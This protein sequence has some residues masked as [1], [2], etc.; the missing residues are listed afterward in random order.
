MPI[1]ET[2]ETRDD[3]D[4]QIKEREQELDQM[5]EDMDIAIDDKIVIADEAEELKFTGVREFSDEIKKHIDDAM[6]AADDKFEEMEGELDGKLEE[7]Q[8][9]EKD[10]FDRAKT[11]AH[12]ASEINDASKKLREAIDARTFLDSAR[13]AADEESF[14]FNESE[15]NQRGIRETSDRRRDNQRTN[16]KNV[17][18]PW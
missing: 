16:L 9:A 4:N 15:D 8:D 13:E 14:F 18:V 2:D 5:A 12:N 6:E 1:R 11:A 3:I 17:N 10:F 7:C